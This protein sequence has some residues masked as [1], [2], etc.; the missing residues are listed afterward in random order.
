MRGYPPRVVTVG[1]RSTHGVA[2]VLRHGIRRQPGVFGSSCSNQPVTSSQCAG[3]PQDP[4]RPGSSS[5]LVWT[6]S[7]LMH[8]LRVMAVTS[9]SEPELVEV[10][11]HVTAQ[12][13][14][15]PMN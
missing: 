8:R 5:P 14:A 10:S 15:R 11:I 6:C 4:Q 9:P 3:R 13:L 1:G 12:D 2:T 7:G